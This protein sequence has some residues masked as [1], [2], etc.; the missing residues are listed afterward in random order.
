[1]ISKENSMILMLKITGWT[2]RKHDAHTTQEINELRSSDKD[3]GRWNK[4]LVPK[5]LV[6]PL[7]AAQRSLREAVKKITVQWIDDGQRIFRSSEF[8]N[9]AGIVNSEISKY[10]AVADTF[11]TEYNNFVMSGQAQAF[12]GNN[13]N[14]ADY[15][16]GSRIR[17]RITAEVKYLPIP[18]SSDWRL[19]NDEDIRKLLEDETENTARAHEIEVRKEISDLVY[20][21]VKNIADRLT[22]DERFRRESFESLTSVADTIELLNLVEDDRIPMIANHLRSLATRDVDQ[23]RSDD[24]FRDAVAAQANSILHNLKGVRDGSSK[25]NNQSQDTSSTEPPVV[26]DATVHAQIYPFERYKDNGD[27]RNSHL[28]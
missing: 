3:A 21:K 27:Q 20:K 11:E 17:S 10:N 7:E 9:V 25:E 8:L 4:M 24:S 22:K 23:I 19:T 28:L 26:L 15:P 13:Y 18:D 16:E 5:S 2:G 1:M 6:Q 14:A 12:M